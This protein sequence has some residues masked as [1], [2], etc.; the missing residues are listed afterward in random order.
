MWKRTYIYPHY[1][2]NNNVGIEFIIYILC[3]ECRII[4]IFYWILKIQN[5]IIENTTTVFVF[6]L[7]LLYP[8]RIFIINKVI[9]ANMHYIVYSLV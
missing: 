6:M 3:Y 5:N 4:E 8:T 2:N 1:N 7:D 9:L